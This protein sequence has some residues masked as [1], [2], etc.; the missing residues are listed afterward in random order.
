MN[1]WAKKLIP[2]MEDAIKLSVPVKVEAKVGDNWGE[3]EK[4]EI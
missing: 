2:L 4:L 3:M 1:A